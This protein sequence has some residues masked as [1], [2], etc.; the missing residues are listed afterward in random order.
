MR[1]IKLICGNCYLLVSNCY[2]VLQLTYIIDFIVELHFKIF[3]VYLTR[4]ELIYY[5]T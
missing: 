2:T 1:A 3:K 5:A 4:L